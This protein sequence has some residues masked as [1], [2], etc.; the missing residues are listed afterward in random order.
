MCIIYNQK[1]VFITHALLFIYTANYSTMQCVT[2]II[3][4]DTISYITYITYYTLSNF[5]LKA[6]DKCVPA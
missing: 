5:F 2:I 6:F 1:S 3:H 4:V